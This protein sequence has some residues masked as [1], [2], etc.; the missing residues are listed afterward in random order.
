MR[1][2]LTMRSHPYMPASGLVSEGLAHGAN[3]AGWRA[4]GY[5]DMAAWHDRAACT[6]A[7]YLITLE[8]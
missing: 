1:D 2:D 5:P 7:L 3:A 6:L 4:V 8:S